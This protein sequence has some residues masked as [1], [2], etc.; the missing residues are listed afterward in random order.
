M[1]LFIYKDGVLTAT[2]AI[3]LRAEGYPGPQV[4]SAADGTMSQGAI[5]FDDPTG[6]LDVHGWQIVRV[7]EPECSSAR[8]LFYGPVGDHIERRG[9]YR[10]A[11]GREIDT[12][13]NDSNIF[14]NCRIITGTDANR[15]AET[16]TARLAWLLASASLSGL[17]YDLGLVA[18]A[19]RLFDATNYRGQYPLDVL[20]DLIAPRGQIFFTYWSQT[21]Q[22]V[23]LFYDSPT[24]TTFTSP[25]SLTNVNSEVDSTH[26]AVNEDWEQAY[27]A[28]DV[29]DHI[30][31]VYAGGAYYA[32]N[33][34]TT[35]AFFNNVIG[36][37]SLTVENDRVG[38]EST[39]ATF[40]ARILARD[41]AENPTMSGTLKIP[42]AQV[43]LIQAGMRIAVHLTHLT[44]FQ[45]VAYSRVKSLT[46][47]QTEGDDTS[48][49]MGLVLSTYG[50]PGAGNWTGP[51]VPQAPPAAASVV[52]TGCGYSLGGTV[53]VTF[54]SQVSAGN[55]IVVAIVERYGTIG[56]T[57]DTD[58]GL[59][60]FHVRSSQIH[61]EE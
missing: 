29:Y 61:G 14:L 23:G 55:R 21:L 54:A 38:L 28:S 2:S 39:A 26:L 22:R 6:V 35:A 30:R 17:V 33:A 42:A 34:T 50:P 31:Y 27:D 40:S 10:L 57:A 13:I 59:R 47:A 49:D 45:T 60:H 9:P 15:P 37:R 18:G 44:G 56:T 1:S 8:T 52:Q 53:E 36:S 32:A 51:P 16:D 3:R 25:L 43:G 12:T 41:G 20:A 24:A 46:I 5:V 19:G 48:H 58:M 4:A 7:D 11:G